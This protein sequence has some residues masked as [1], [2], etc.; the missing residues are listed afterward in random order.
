[1]IYAEKDAEG[2]SYDVAYN[3]RVNGCII[4]YYNENSDIDTACKYADEKRYACVIRAYKDGTLMIKDMIK[5]EITQTTIQE[6]L[7]Y[8]EE[9]DECDCGCGEHHHDHDNCSCGKHHHE[10]DCCG[11]HEH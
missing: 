2:I 9:E 4:E 6:F 11:H 8:Y 7:G 5:D 1:M 10:H 3:L